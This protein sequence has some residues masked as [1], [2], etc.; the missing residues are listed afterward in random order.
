M[1]YSIYTK[2][3]RTKPVL[4]YVVEAQNKL[5]VDELIDEAVKNVKV[6]E[7]SF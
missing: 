1:L 5:P 2:H 4:K 6:T 3:P 7:I